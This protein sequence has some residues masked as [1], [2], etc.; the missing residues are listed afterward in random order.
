MERRKKMQF[1]DKDENNHL[2]WALSRFEWVTKEKEPS[3][4]TL[5]EVQNCFTTKD[6]KSTKEDEALNN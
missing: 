6:T 3:A 2:I 5:A 4:K 1:W